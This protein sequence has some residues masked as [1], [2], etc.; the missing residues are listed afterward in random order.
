MTASDTFW[1]EVPIYILVDVPAPYHSNRYQ[2]S[3]EENC[4]L[5]IVNFVAYNLGRGFGKTH[6]YVLFTITKSTAFSVPIMLCGISILNNALVNLAVAY[7]KCTLQGR[8]N[9]K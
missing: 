9:F 6:S 2:V 5:L 8:T 4:M 3:K 1:V 7:Y